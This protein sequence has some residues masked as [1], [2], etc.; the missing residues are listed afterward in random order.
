MDL[1]LTAI[2]L[3]IAIVLI[4]IAWQWGYNAGVQATEAPTGFASM[5]GLD[6]FAVRELVKYEKTESGVIRVYNY[7]QPIEPPKGN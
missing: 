7:Y 3:V 6:E 2:G 1:N 5:P 4:F